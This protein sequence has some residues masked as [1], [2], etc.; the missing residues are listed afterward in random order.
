MA[1][2]LHM[3]DLDDPTHR[4]DYGSPSATHGNVGKGLS[5]YGP[6]DSQHNDWIDGSTLTVVYPEQ[7][8]SAGERLIKVLKT[9]YEWFGGGF[10]SFFRVDDITING[11]EMDGNSVANY[12]QAA[13]EIVRRNLDGVA[14][15]LTEER[16]KRLGQVS[17]YW[18]AKA[19]LTEQGIP[20]QMMMV[21]N[22]RS[23][24]DLKYAIVN[25]VC[26][27]YAKLGGKPWGVEETGYAADLVVGIGRSYY[28]P[29]KH[30]SP[31][32]TLGFAAAYQSNGAFFWFDSETSGGDY[33]E[34]ESKLTDSICNV[35]DEY[36][37]RE[38]SPRRII[39]HSP[40]RIG[41]TERTAR[42]RI[43]DE[44]DNTEVVLLHLNTDH[45]Y[46]THDP[47]HPT[48]LPEPGWFLQTGA[49][50]GLVVTDGRKQFRNGSASPISMTVEGINEITRDDLV[51][52]AQNTFSLCSVYWKDQMGAGTPIT[53]RYAEDIADMFE[54]SQY[55]AREQVVSLNPDQLVN[56]R[57]QDRPWFL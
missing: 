54:A 44:Y 52:L 29:E 55:L 36:V 14:V 24:Y 15:F 53:L 37:K 1:L 38:Q 26:Q 51:G 49:N 13:D 34:L 4:F 17:P 5:Q 9:G 18:V 48:G 19:K 57:L 30:G 20:T 35:V 40:E 32:R 46:K 31:D 23:D 28:R 47:N 22:V 3:E 25:T 50:K 21:E 33:S 12:K 8:R 45:P 6:L 43:E 11:L 42:R 7:W 27:I 56:E 39:V 41:K 2:R 16:M 10:E